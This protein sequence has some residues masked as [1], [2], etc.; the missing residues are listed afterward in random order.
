MGDPFQLPVKRAVC[1]KGLQ[2]SRLVPTRDLPFTASYIHT[3][4]S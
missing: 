4:I 2:D 3:L 1:L